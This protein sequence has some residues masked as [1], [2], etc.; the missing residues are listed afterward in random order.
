MADNSYTT[1][2]RM[3]E[4]RGKRTLGVEN[5]PPEENFYL[6]FFCFFAHWRYNRSTLAHRFDRV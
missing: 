4:K 5:D 1:Y 2:Y 3:L 6:V